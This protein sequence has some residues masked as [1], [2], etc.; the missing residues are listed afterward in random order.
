MTRGVRL[1]KR[2]HPRLPYFMSS[3]TNCLGALKLGATA[4]RAVDI[5]RSRPECS[6][7]QLSRLSFA[8]VKG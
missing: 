7:A 8:F 5:G 6:S 4:G 2:R 1:E 3:F